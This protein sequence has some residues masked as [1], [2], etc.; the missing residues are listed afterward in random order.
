MF[1]AE[2]ILLRKESRRLPRREWPKAI[3]GKVVVEESEPNVS[4]FR[5]LMR[6]LTLTQRVGASSMRTAA[7]L[8]DPY[9]LPSVDGA[10]M[11]AGIELMASGERGEICEHGQ[12][13]M[14]RTRATPDGEREALR[15]GVERQLP[16]T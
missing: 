3:Y 14:C 9:F 6:K 10:M 15:S 16:D 12:I 4:N 2:V 1:F 8:F 13:W 5:R 7:V 11:I